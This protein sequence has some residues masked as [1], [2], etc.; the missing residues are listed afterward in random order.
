MAKLFSLK[1]LQ[2]GD[3]NMN[4]FL[5]RTGIQI[6]NKCVITLAFETKMVVGKSHNSGFKT[7]LPLVHVVDR[8]E[9]RLGISVIITAYI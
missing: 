9:G 5:F 4:T 1:A 3:K 2:K 8:K 7:F 6:Y